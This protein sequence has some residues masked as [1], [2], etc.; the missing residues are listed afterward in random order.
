MATGNILAEGNI[1]RAYIVT[2]T[3]D[4]GGVSA[5]NTLTVNVTVPGVLPGDYV[6]GN[7]ASFNPGLGLFNFTVTAPNN[8]QFRV[9][10]VTAGSL[11]PSPQAMQ[12][13]IIRQDSTRNAF[14]V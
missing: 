4:I 1:D 14:G 5:N 12:F 9:G 6:W 3:V 7:I 10:N 11:D 8:V 13:L 2:Q